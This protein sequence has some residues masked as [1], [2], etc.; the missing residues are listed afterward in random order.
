MAKDKK[1]G[2]DMGEYRPTTEEI[3]A[4]SWCINHSIYIS[5]KATNKTTE[6]YLVITI[7]GNDNTSPKT[8]KKDEI[9]KKLYEYYK[10]YYEKYE[11]KI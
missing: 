2:V 1:Y 5:P 11:T 6:W 8:F 9:W 3:K 4:F 10:Y 7:N